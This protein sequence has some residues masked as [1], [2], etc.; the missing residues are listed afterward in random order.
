MPPVTSLAD[1][2]SPVVTIIKPREYNIKQVKVFGEP[3]KSITYYDD[4]ME[5]YSEEIQYWIAYSDVPPEGKADIEYIE[6]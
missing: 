6:E 4:V 1:K 5:D 3:V 2:G